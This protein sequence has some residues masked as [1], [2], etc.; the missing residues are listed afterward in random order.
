MSQRKK[1]GGGVLG[2]LYSLRFKDLFLHW[3]NLQV[4]EFSWW[5][6]HVKMAS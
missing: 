3:D 5:E 1:D 6:P 2:K 4:A